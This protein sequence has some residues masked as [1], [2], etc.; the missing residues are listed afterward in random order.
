MKLTEIPD[1][2][3]AE[4]MP[5]AKKI[6]SALGAQDYNILQNNGRIAHQVVDHVHFHVIPKPDEQQ[7]LGISWP[8]QKVDMDELK[9]L[10]EQL[11]SKM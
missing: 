8:Q 4:A 6:A 5:V 10:H 9:Q 11:K 3:L 2:E 7:G 1:D